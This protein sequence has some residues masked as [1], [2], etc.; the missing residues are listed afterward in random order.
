LIAKGKRS[1][2]V[3]RSAA[4]ITHYKNL[5]RPA[6]VLQLDFPRALYLRQKL[7]YTSSVTC[8]NTTTFSALTLLLNSA[9]DFFQAFGSSQP[10]MYNMLDGIYGRY[11]V[12]GGRMVVNVDSMIHANAAN[13]PTG[14]VKL[15]FSKEQNGTPTSWRQIAEYP[16]SK[17]AMVPL[18]RDSDTNVYACPI[19]NNHSITFSW[20]TYKDII[21]DNDI[22]AVSSANNTDPSRK[23]YGYI[24]FG[25]LDPTT[26]TAVINFTI[27]GYLDV[28][29]F[30]PGSPSPTVDTTLRGVQ[31]FVDID[32]VKNDVQQLEP[33]STR[34]VCCK[35]TLK[36]RNG[37]K[38]LPNGTPH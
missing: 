3:L 18:Q 24:G 16:Y 14:T 36:S 35:D 34:P 30:D 21:G 15:A 1:R 20:D 5:F 10:Y 4:A 23:L 31:D 8:V 33:V 22:Y 13:I 12:T 19:G 17:T 37:N 38:V 26:S 11:L 27:Y 2:R 28:I 6:P 32:D 29:W 9:Y 7:S 25:F